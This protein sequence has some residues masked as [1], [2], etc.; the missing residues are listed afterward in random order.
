MSK[1]LYIDVETTGL[2]KTKAGLTQLAAIVV[3]NGEEIDKIALDINPASYNREVEITERALEVTGKTLEDLA[4]YPLSGQQFKKFIAFL[5][6]HVNKFNKED[7]F[8]P[9]AY[10]SQF[11][12]GFLQEWFIDNEHKFFGSYFTYK[13]VDVFGLVKVLAHL[14]LI[15]INPVGGTHTLGALCDMYGISLGDDAHDAI[16]DIRATRELYQLLIDKFINYDKS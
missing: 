1:S 3:I 9:I 11:D 8:I 16:A 6:K 2:D 15:P 4:N 7:K 5:D 12:M 10:N 13:D 14:K